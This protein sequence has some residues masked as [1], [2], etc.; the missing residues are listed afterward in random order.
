MD[1]GEFA[2]SHEHREKDNSI[3]HCDL[4]FA[5]LV[6]ADGS[7][8]WCDHGSLDPDVGYCVH[9]GAAGDKGIRIGTPCDDPFIA[10]SEKKE[11]VSQ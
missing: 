4:P 3:R 11:L 7:L 2:M 8:T 10:R 1:K 9:S 5:H 6:D